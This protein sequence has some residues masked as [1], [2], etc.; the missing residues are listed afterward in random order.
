MFKD[1]HI[2]WTRPLVRYFSCVLM[3]K[4]QRCR[5]ARFDTPLRNI[6]GFWESKFEEGGRGLKIDSFFFV[7]LFYV[8]QGLK[9][10]VIQVKLVYFTVQSNRAF[11]FLVAFFFQK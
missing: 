3:K 7:W 10:Y 8:A 6:G 1:V 2:S 5:I 11:C 9:T 4:R